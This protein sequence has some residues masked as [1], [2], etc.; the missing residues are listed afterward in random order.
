MVGGPSPSCQVHLPFLPGCNWTG[1][2]L[3][4]IIRKIADLR[5]FFIF[6]TTAVRLLSNDI[7]WVSTDI[8]SI[9]CIIFHTYTPSICCINLYPHS[10]GFSF[11]FYWGVGLLITWRGGLHCSSP[12]RSALCCMSPS[13]DAASTSPMLSCWREWRSVSSTT[14]IIE[15][16]INAKHKIH[17]CHVG[18]V[19][20]MRYCDLN[21]KHDQVWALG[22]TIQVQL[23]HALCST[24]LIL[25]TSEYGLK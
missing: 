16:E 3:T 19:P 22:C 9:I 8:S 6:E 13:R 15:H 20:C 21:A 12:P 1:G 4:L 5:Y 11:M 2:G 10:L 14:C 24:W 17:Q 23:W 7:R 25:C 18:L